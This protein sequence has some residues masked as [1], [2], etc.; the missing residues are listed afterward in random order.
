LT[1]SDPRAEDVSMLDS[2]DTEPPDCSMRMRREL[3][4]TVRVMSDVALIAAPKLE[5]YAARLVLNVVRAATSN[6][7]NVLRSLV[8]NLM[9]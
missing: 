6:C 8:V 5:R 1:A 3:L 2:T 7:A 4:V 9:R